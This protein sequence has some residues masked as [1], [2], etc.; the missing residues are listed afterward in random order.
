[1]R[2]FWFISVVGLLLFSACSK[3]QAIQKSPDPFKK[4]EAAMKYYDKK[5]YYRSGMLFEEIIPL[6]K[7]DP[8]SEEAQFRYAYTQFHQGMLELSAFHFNKFYETYARSP[9]ATEARYMYAYSL[10]E[11]SPEYNL[12]QTN[13]YKAI[14]A[15][16][17]FI[18]AYP[19][20][21]FAEKAT[22]LLMEERR[23]L[24]KKAY[25]TAKLFNKIQDYHKAA[26]VVFNNF[27]RVYPESDYSEEIAF[28]KLEAEY[29]LAKKSTDNRKKERY[30]AAVEFYDVFLEK[31]PN[32]KFI[33][34][35]EDMYTASLK[36]LRDK[37]FKPEEKKKDSTQEN[38]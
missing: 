6:I 8:R 5:D 32:S 3:F 38:N 27:Q 2:I 33:R 36:A 37:N 31:Y 12:D 4:Y 35:A 25:E 29:K 10:Y 24:E 9:H 19:D 23:K 18:N 15:L 20:S 26:V 28:K 34:Q 17:A 13:T 21:E 30:Q 14:D 1:M 11:D 7:G 16:Q 22:K